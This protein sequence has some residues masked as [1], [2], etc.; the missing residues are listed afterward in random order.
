MRVRAPDG[1]RQHDAAEMREGWRDFWSPH[2]AVGDRA[3]VRR[4][5]NAVETG[6]TDVLGP[7]IA[8]THYGGAGWFGVILDRRGRRRLVSGA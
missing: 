5:C 8:K 4:S 7:K 3:P 6:S 1:G 2:V